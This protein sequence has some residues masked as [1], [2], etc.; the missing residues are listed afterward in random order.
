MYSPYL[1]WAAASL[2]LLVACGVAS[3]KFCKSTPAWIEELHLLGL[4]RKRKLPGTAVICG[5]SIAGIVTA[6][7]CADHFERVIIVDPEMQDAEKPKTRIMQY[8]STHGRLTDTTPQHKSLTYL[9]I[10]FLSLFIDGARK[11]WP[12]IDDEILATGGRTCPADTQVHYSGVLIPT[13]YRDYPP[14]QF[15]DTLVIRR[16]KL[17]TVLH[18]LMI[19]HSSAATITVLAGTTRGIKISADGT[20]IKSVVVRDP[21]GV[22]LSLDNVA[23][24]AGEFRLMVYFHY[25]TGATQAGLRWLKAAGLPLSN[26][27]RRCYNAN[28]RYVTIDFTVSPAL[29]A[30]LPI[31]EAHTKSITIYVYVPHDDSKAC[32]VSFLKTEN[33]T[34]ASVP[35]QQKMRLILDSATHALNR[36]QRYATDPRRSRSIYQGIPRMH[37]THSRLVDQSYVQYSLAPPGALPSNFV[38]LGDASLQLNPVHGQGFGKIMLNG[39]TLNSILHAIDSPTLLPSNFGA[40]YFKKS[41]SPMKELWITKLPSD[42]GSSSCEPMK[43]ETRDTGRIMRWLELKLLSAATQDEEVASAFWHVR[44]MRA[45]DIAF[46][47]PTVLWKVIKTRSIF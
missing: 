15:P 30:K 1:C 40:R 27:L 31:P 46:F 26:D 21:S 5:G 33:D 18:R 37:P 2:L 7:I 36:R 47:A 3:Q 43:G 10:G 17:Q 29:A 6:R 42:Y 24:L 16:S 44:H 14:G 41:A 22:H 13:P 8:Y 9:A 23:I 28:L 45:R 12:D 11:L 20:V 38:A 32:Y 39:I 25:C 19:R 35:I 4:P 34:S